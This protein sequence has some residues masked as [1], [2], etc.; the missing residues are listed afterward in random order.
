M[1]A[2]IRTLFKGPEINVALSLGG[3]TAPY[4]KPV[5]CRGSRNAEENPAGLAF[6]Q[7]QIETSTLCVRK[8]MSHDSYLGKDTIRVSANSAGGSGDCRK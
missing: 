7:M 8:G 5:L 3:R 6:C 4:V 1:V 2:E